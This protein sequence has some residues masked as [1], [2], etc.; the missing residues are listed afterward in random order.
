[1]AT[2]SDYGLGPHEYP[3]GWF[4]VADASDV[5]RAPQAVRFFGQDLALYR[6]ES[7]K[8]VMLDAYCPHMGTHLAANTTSFVIQDGLQVEGDSIRCPY[9]AWRFGPDGRCND[10]PYFKGP[11]P[12]SARVRSWRV[13]ER[14]GCVFAWHD[15]EGGEPDCELPA[16]PEW[17]EGGW[18]HW[19]LDKLGTLPCH[20]QELIDNMA[21][22]AHLGPTHGAPCEYFRN[23]INDVVCRQLQ[24]GKHRSITGGGLLE[25]DTYYTGPGIL[26]SRFVGLGSIMFI[27]HTPVDDG[28]V[29]AWHGLLVQAGHTPPTEEDVAAARVAQDYSRAAFAQ[30]F[31]IWANKKPAL[32][33]LQVPTD[34]PYAKVRAWYKQFYHPRAD[35]ARLQQQANG[36]FTV[37]DMPSANARAA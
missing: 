5:S 10:I 18:V 32:T 14:Y 31:E 34:G 6:G 28:S 11:I 22:V 24:G 35:A 36:M 17:D 16:L 23:E 25:T 12:A 29:R 2:T 33:I 20:S 26:L 9:H 1:M 21:D 3:R 30:D 8:V 4:M 15:M 7:G 37:R 27:T 19:K 13:E